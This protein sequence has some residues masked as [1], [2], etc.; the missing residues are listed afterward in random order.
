MDVETL[1]VLIDSSS[2]LLLATKK[3]IRVKPS[4]N[5]QMHQ[6]AGMQFQEENVT[7]QTIIWLTDRTVR[8]SKFDECLMKT[9]QGPSN[10]SPLGD[11]AGS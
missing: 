7:V 11:C 10:L 4:L 8:E 5:P 1:D 6:V 3:T 2:R 9:R